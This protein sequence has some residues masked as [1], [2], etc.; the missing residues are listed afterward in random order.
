MKKVKKKKEKKLNWM[1]KSE[2]EYIE[3]YK[4]AQ[5][6]LP[7][8]DNLGA[9]WAPNFEL[10][11]YPGLD[12]LGGLEVYLA[13]LSK[14]SKKL[15]KAAFLRQK[16]FDIFLKNTSEDDNHK[17]WRLGMNEVAADAVKTLQYWTKVRD[18]LLSNIILE[19]GSRPIENFTFDPSTRNVDSSYRPADKKSIPRISRMKASPAQKK[20]RQKLTKKAIAARKA[21]ETKLLESASKDYI[22]E[23]T[24]F[25]YEDVFIN[26]KIIK[27]SKMITW[28]DVSE[29]IKIHDH[30]NT[31]GIIFSPANIAWDR[32]ALLHA[33]N[34][35]AQ[36]FASYIC[37]SEEYC[38]T[39]D[40][41]NILVRIMN[42]HSS[43]YEIVGFTNGLITQTCRLLQYSEKE[44]YI[45][46]GMFVIMTHLINMRF[47]ESPSSNC[48]EFLKDLEDDIIGD[49]KQWP[50]FCTSVCMVYP[51]YKEMRCAVCISP[52]ATLDMT[53]TQAMIILDTYDIKPIPFKPVISK[54]FANNR[55]YVEYIANYTWFY[56]RSKAKI[57]YI[58]TH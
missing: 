18:D 53:K 22:E 5:Y 3:D 42:V 38:T 44:P 23:K 51:I 24:K 55:Q 39:T 4:R 19:Y 49:I 40:K 21:A 32:H 46:D 16:H 56:N 13:Q 20:L 31:K 26:P 10:E 47:I 8:S 1:I 2:S 7:D 58:A 41:Y 30:P 36:A 37:S 11:N 14:Y 50:K 33:V 54:Q 43:L 9:L 52:A 48:D 12:Y 34:E 57:L 25:N 15:S 28:N 29:F 27:D 45:G 6:K 17:H 35:L